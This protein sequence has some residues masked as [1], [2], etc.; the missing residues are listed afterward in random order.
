MLDDDRRA[1]AEAVIPDGCE[2]FGWIYTQEGSRVGAAILLKEVERELGLSAEFGARHMAA[3][4]DGRAPH[5]RRFKAA[6][7][8][9]GLTVG[10]CQRAVAGARAAFRFMQHSVDDLM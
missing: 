5:W 4:P 8:A 2:A 10:E 9:L 6:L 1:A 3:H 7:D